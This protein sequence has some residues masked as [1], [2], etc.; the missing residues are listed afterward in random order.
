MSVF[1]DKRYEELDWIS[2]ATEPVES[3]LNDLLSELPDEFLISDADTYLK[4]VGESWGMNINRSRV[5]S[6]MIN[7]FAPR[8]LN[9]LSWA[10]RESLFANFELELIGEPLLNFETG[11][12]DGGEIRLFK[13]SFSIDQDKLKAIMG[14]KGLRMVR[15]AHNSTES[16]YVS[17]CNE[18][19]QLIGTKDALSG[20]RTRSKKSKR[21]VLYRCLEKLLKDNEWNIKSADLANKIGAWMSDYIAHGNL[22]SMSNLCRLKVMTHR[23]LPIYSMEEVQ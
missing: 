14:E 3:P 10:E 11:K 13:T 17:R 19:L 23:G 16:L 5:V 18:I 4:A 7:K 15:D 21:I 1:V 22:A 6:Y 2:Q 12:M 20:L 8:R 9:D